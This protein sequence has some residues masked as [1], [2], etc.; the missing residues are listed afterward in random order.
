MSTLGTEF[1]S[2]V[3]QLDCFM[4]IK[5]NEISHILYTFWVNKVAWCLRFSLGQRAKHSTEEVN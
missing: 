3:L 1:I 5:C 2:K 4:S